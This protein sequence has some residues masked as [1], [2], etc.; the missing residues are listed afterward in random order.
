MPITRRHRLATAAVRASGRFRLGDR[1]APLHGPFGTRRKGE[2]ER[3]L[4]QVRGLAVEPGDD[5]RIGRDIDAE[6]LP[7]YGSRFST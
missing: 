4:V 7:V 1:H 6:S 2:G 5:V 3:V